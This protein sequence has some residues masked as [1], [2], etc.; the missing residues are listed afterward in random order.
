M[1]KKLTRN[2]VPYIIYKHI[3]RDHRFG[4]QEYLKAFPVVEIIAHPA[5]Q[6][7]IA[8]LQTLIYSKD[9]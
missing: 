2:P 8:G 4:T 9:F 5:I 7:I 3:H 1:I 6:D